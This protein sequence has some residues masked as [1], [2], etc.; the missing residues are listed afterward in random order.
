MGSGLPVA[1]ALSV[2]APAIE[3]GSIDAYN[4]SIKAINDR[5][6]KAQAFKMSV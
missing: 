5:Q 6:L 3:Q 2:V 1:A 4:K